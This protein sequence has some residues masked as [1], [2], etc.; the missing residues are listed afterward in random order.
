MI[1]LIFIGPGQRGTTTGRAVPVALAEV[2][3]A[4]GAEIRMASSAK[5]RG[6]PFQARWRPLS[7][8]EED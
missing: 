8:E 1:S 3:A 5:S 2:V 6:R 4:T 7:H